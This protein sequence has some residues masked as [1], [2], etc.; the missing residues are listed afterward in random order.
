MVHDGQLSA[1]L[2][3]TFLPSK[4]RSIAKVTFKTLDRLL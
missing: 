3:I 4:E 1:L 2:L